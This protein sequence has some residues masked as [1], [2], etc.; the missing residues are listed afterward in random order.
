MKKL[1]TILVSATM[2]VSL[3]TGCGSGNVE[4]DV[5]KDEGKKSEEVV[6]IKFFTGKVETVDLLNEIIDEFNSTHPNIVVEQE[7][8]KDASNTIKVKFASGD[9]PDITT[10]VAQDYIDQGK[11]LD[12]SKEVWWDRIQPSIKDMCTD[13]KTGNQYKVA[14]NMTMAGLFYNKEIFKDL[15][16]EEP[17]TWEEFEKNLTAIKES[18]SEI[19]PFF[20]GGKESWMLG[21][22]VE[23]MA[24]GVVKQKYGV[25][26]AKEAFLSNDDSKLQFGEKNGPIDSFAASILSLK[27]KGLLNKD[28]L[29]A[30]YD[31]Q[32]ESF[33][34]GQA[35]VISQGMWALGGILEKNPDMASNI[36]FMPYPAIVDG[37]ESVILS[38]EDSAYAITSASEHPEEAKEFLNFLF[39][40]QNLKKYSE[41][42]K[43]P[44]AFKDVEADWGPIK[45]EV[46]KAL[47][48]GVNIG[49]TNENPSG[50]S[51]DDA[52]RLV[53][54]LYAGQYATSLDFAKAYKET[55]D[56]AW[57]ASNN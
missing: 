35:A 20:M 42:V 57:N 47:E 45:D 11:Y 33:A 22:L 23:F 43:S 2:L 17:K 41:F 53:Q 18:N 21:H 32:I 19:S 12:L 55:W 6:N 15:G 28:F 36:G 29:T 37:T 7:F 25:T 1:L 14:S 46:A 3:V 51:G 49:F 31:N 30:T 39:E 8:Q 16:L 52:G 54:E 9:I 13:V 50:F 24:H 5:K 27:E 40:K 26:G 34:N 44:C 48:S 38:A 56:N 10:V 4:N